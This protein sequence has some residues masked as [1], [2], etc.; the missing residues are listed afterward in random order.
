[1][2]KREVE[3]SLESMAKTAA[4]DRGKDEEVREKLRNT[5]NKAN[6][7]Q[8]IFLQQM[9]KAIEEEKKE[10]EAKEKKAE[11]R[12]NEKDKGKKEMKEKDEREKERTEKE[13]REK[14]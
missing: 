13:K 9:D 12:R 4:L 6:Q 11:E 5:Y 10:E 3:D 2:L 1:M 7:A 14:K 8:L